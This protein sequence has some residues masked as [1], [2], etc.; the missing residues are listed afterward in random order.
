MF[1]QNHCSENLRR[2]KE[3]NLFLMCFLPVP[4]LRSTVCPSVRMKQLEIA[5]CIFTKFDINYCATVAVTSYDGVRALLRA[6]RSKVLC[7]SVTACWREKCLEQKAWRK[8]KHPLLVDDWWSNT[9]WL[10]RCVCI[11]QLERIV[12][13]NSRLAIV[14]LYVYCTLWHAENKIVNTVVTICT[15]CVNK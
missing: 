9:P 12:L 1:T 15:T 3:V 10:L 14:S 13:R 4:V 8:M 6:G 2:C 5:K 11:S 7:K